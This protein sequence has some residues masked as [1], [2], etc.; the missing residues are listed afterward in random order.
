MEKSSCKKKM[1]L[2]WMSLLDF[3]LSWS[4]RILLLV[5]EFLLG[6]NFDFVSIVHSLIS[7]R[8]NHVE[9]SLVWLMNVFLVVVCL[10]SWFRGYFVTVEHVL[11]EVYSIVLIL[12]VFHVSHLRQIVIYLRKIFVAILIDWLIGT[13]TKRQRRISQMIDR[14]GCTSSSMES[15][16][17][18]V[19]SVFELFSL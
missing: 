8:R 3:W 15:I 18:W 14:I 11:S 2:K 10:S 7:L 16:F 4:D 13:Y 12:R 5:F 17:S 9:V 19:L 6:N 1:H